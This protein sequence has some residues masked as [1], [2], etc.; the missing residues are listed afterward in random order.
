MVMALMKTSLIQ[1]IHK[2]TTADVVHSSAYAK[3]QHNNGG[4]PH[5]GMSFSARTQ[6]D[7]NRTYV[8]GY[9][10]S[11]VMREG[12]KR[13]GATP[14]NNQNGEPD[15][16]VPVAPQQKVQENHFGWRSSQDTMASWGYKNDVSSVGQSNADAAAAAATS[17]ATWGYG[18]KS[19]DKESLYTGYGRT[20][21]D[22][23][24]LHKGYARQ[25]G[26]KESLHKGYGRVSNAEAA[27]K[28]TGYANAAAQRQARAA[29]FSGAVAKTSGSAPR[30]SINPTFGPHR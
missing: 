4:G 8:K 6:V 14:V 25:A 21:G 26:D 24:S 27:S 7:Q 28:K 1:R 22:R 15:V 16:P 19:G 10:D 18:R 20:S 13:P 3:V 30:P 23:E 12:N 11:M 17:N 9:K 29:R 2:T 5:S